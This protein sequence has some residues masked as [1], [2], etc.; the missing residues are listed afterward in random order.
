MAL[1]PV[2]KTVTALAASPASLR[3]R[4]KPRVVAHLTFEQGDLDPIIAG[5]LE[6]IEKRHML[7]D[8]VGGPEQEIETELH[9]KALR[10][11]A[12]SRGKCLS[13]ELLFKRFEP[14]DEHAVA[15]LSDHRV[16]GA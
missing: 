3:F 4:A 10:L 9:C 14:T 8:D 2:G 11:D 5:R 13:G 12:G 7:V 15:D 16:F 1:L 6:A